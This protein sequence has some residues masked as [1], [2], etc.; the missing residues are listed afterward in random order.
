MEEKICNKLNDLTIT[1]FNLLNMLI[2]KQ[3][4]FYFSVKN[5]RNGQ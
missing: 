1:S 5:L 2:F 4:I 3:I